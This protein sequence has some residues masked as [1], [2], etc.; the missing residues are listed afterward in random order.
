MLSSRSLKLSLILFFI[1]AGLGALLAMADEETASTQEGDTLV[2]AP[3]TANLL[4]R[5]MDD[6]HAVLQPLWHESYPEEDL[7]TIR[8]KAPLLQEKI[9]A[10]IRVPAPAEFS[11]EEEKLHT[12]LSKR[13][14]LAFYVMEFNRAAK[15]G[16]DSTLASAFETMHWGYEELEKFFAVQIEELDKFHE[17]LYYLWHRALPARDY[18]EIRKTAP[19][20][21]AEMDSLMKVPVPSGCNIKE[22]E[23]EKRKTALKDAVYNFAQTCEKGT[24]DQ[25]DAALKVLHDRFAELNSLL[26]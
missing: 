4:R 24:E 6:F 20:I 25:I 14:E 21:K 7:K 22:E 17:T 13:Q 18:P 23:F 26:R 11:Q 15:D 8:E 3:D 10:L 12:F 5:A 16:P 19:I 1:L 9:M 2:V